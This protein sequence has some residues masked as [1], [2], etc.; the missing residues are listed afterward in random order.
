M[1]WGETGT[2]LSG[3]R[4][5]FLPK[6]AKGLLGWGGLGAAGIWEGRDWLAEQAQKYP[7]LLGSNP[8]LALGTALK[9]GEHKFGASQRK[10][11][12]LAEMQSGYPKHAS[13]ALPVAGFNKSMEDSVKKAATEDDEEEDPFNYNQLFIA[14]ILKGLKQKPP[15]TA[16]GRASGTYIPK[17]D[18]PKMSDYD[19][20]KTYWNIG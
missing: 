7:G 19:S 8:L 12:T 4:L 6:V 15:A 20:N 11:D 18:L 9:A 5:S 17:P 10:A 1:A 16:S 3:T 14:S 13:G 2:T